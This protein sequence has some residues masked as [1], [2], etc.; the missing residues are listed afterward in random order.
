MTTV[1]EEDL[2]LV[3]G[4]RAL[5]GWESV[6]V[7]LSLEAA[8]G[9]FQVKAS[10]AAP[11]P[12]RVGQ[13]V[14]VRVG[15]ELLIRG[16]VDDVEAR[17]DASSRSV[18]AS[19]RDKAADL[20]DCSELSE[21][22]EWLDV[23]LFQLLELIVRPF[24]VTVRNLLEEELEPF[25][26]FARQPGES[27]WSMIERACRLRGVLVHADGEGGLL[28][29]RPGK[30]LADVALIEGRNVLAWSVRESSRQR[31]AHYVVRAQS[32]GADEFYGEQAA[33]V[34]GTADDPGVERFRPLLVLAEGALAFEGAQDRARWEAT[35]RAARAAVV[36]C[37]VRGWRQRPGGRLWRPNLLSQ[38]VLRGA[39][40]DQTLLVSEVTLTRDREQGTLSQVSL[41]RADAFDPQ[42]EVDPDEGLEWGDEDAE[43]EDLEGS[44]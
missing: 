42:P 21:P 7:T 20:V 37:T 35:V 33:L 16:F 28:L 26:R 6:Q 12:L 39:A 4:G 27:A 29:E 31:F 23:D 34:E 1:Q 2:E 17:G 43:G 15:G 36:T 8:S 14:D 40:L 24:G 5:S 32:S 22:G 44:F 19:G 10:G 13:D 18:S 3:V 41:I 38:V 11:S 30:E 25:V 9:T